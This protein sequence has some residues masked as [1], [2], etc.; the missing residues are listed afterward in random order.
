MHGSLFRK[1][2]DI[3]YLVPITKTWI[4]EEEAMMLVRNSAIAMRKSSRR[5]EPARSIFN[6]RFEQLEKG[7]F[8]RPSG[9][10]AYKKAYERDFTQGHSS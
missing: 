8:M 4:S 5:K 7:A 1:K 6:F 9:E 10:E 2:E 3:K